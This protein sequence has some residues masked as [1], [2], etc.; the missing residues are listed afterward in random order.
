MRFAKKISLL[1][2]VLIFLVRVSAQTTNENIGWFAWFNTYR[3]SKDWGFY[4]D[5]QIRSA[6]DWSYVRTLLLRPGITY[7]FDAKN[8]VTI[9][10]AYIASYNQLPAPSKNRLDES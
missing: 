5:G 1:I 7:F 3:F 2:I 4:F 6:D 8:N 9:G 10:Y